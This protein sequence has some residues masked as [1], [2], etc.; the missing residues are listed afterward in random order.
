MAF[1]KASS[2][3]RPWRKERWKAT[4]KVAVL[5]SATFHWLA[6]MERAPAYCNARV[7]PISPSPFTS[8][9]RPVSQP[10]NGNG[11]VLRH[12]QRLRWSAVEEEV[13]SLAEALCGFGCETRHFVLHVIAPA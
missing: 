5:R 10:G 3:G 11:F 12:R 1:C 9:P 4:I 13:A 8:W 2:L 7:R 6:T